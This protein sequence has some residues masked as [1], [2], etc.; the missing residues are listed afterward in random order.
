[1]SRDRG[2]TKNIISNKAA[3]SALLPELGGG[4]GKHTALIIPSAQ[5][6][7]CKKGLEIIPAGHGDGAW[8]LCDS[9]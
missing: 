1:M 2:S 9:L 8:G 5:A 7:V 6:G 3:F 4:P